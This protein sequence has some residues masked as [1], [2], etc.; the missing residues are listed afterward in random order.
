V[1]APGAT[2]VLRGLTINGQGG[3]TGINIQQAARIR[4]E[5]CSVSNMTGNGVLHAALA[6]DVVILDTIVRDNAGNGISITVDASVTLDHVRSERNGS[7][8]FY[9]V[10]S[11]SETHA[12]IARSLFVSNALSG[13]LADTTPTAS[14]FIDVDDSVLSSN[15]QHGF[16]GNAKF[17]SLLYA[18]VTRST[19]HRNAGRGAEFVSDPAS[20]CPP[21][22]CAANGVL[23]GNSIVGNGVLA[24]EAVNPGTR[25]VFG[26]NT[27]A[28]NE[29][30]T[31]GQV[32]SG[33]AYSSGNNVGIAGGSYISSTTF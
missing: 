18:T 5:G 30:S 24:I 19:L 13:V 2:V 17:N 23:T 33:K 27:F 11:A 15:G 28:W 26:A 31:I 29:F 25:L 12:T 14:T 21:S 1:N 6:A 9:I 16:N 7:N 8:G 4:I 22:A 32:N 20:S 3:T 10:P